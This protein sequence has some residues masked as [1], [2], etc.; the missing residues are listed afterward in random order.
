MALDAGELAAIPGLARAVAA[1]DASALEALRTTRLSVAAAAL[2][3]AADPET[4]ALRPEILALVEAGLARFPVLPEESEAGA[5]AAARMAAPEGLFAAALLL[6][7]HDLPAIPDLAPMSPAMRAVVGTALLIAPALF[8]SESE[9]ERHAERMEAIVEAFHRVVVGRPEDPHRVALGLIFAQRA[10]LLMAYFSR[11]NLRR[12]MRLRGEIIEA[13][14]VAARRAPAHVFGAR[15]PGPL[16]V[17]VLIQALRPFTETYLAISQFEAKDPDTRLT[18][19]ALDAAPG[20]IE[21]LARAKADDYVVLGSDLEAQ[22]ARLRSDDLDALAI[23]SNVTA[24]VNPVALLA[25][26]RS[27]RVQIVSTVTPATSGFASG[28]AYLSGADNEPGENPQSDYTE[29]LYRVPGIVNYYAY[30]HDRDPATVSVAR[31]D[32]GLPEGAPVFFS[33][34]NFF[35]L[36]PELTALWARVLAQVPEAR[37]LIMPFAPSWSSTYFSRPF[38]ERIEAQFAAAGVGRDRWRAV[39]PVPARADLHRIAAL[40]DVYLDAHPFSGA[41]SLID[42]LSVGLPVVTLAGTRFRGHVGAAMLAGAGLSGMV[43]RDEADYVAKAAALARDPASRRAASAR[44]RAAMSPLPPYFDV[45]AAGRKLGD[46]VRSLTAARDA[47]LERLRGRASADLVGAIERVARRASGTPLFRA[48]TDT[49]IVKL[50][51]VPYLRDAAQQGHAIDVGACV[52]ETASP[53]LE[54]GWGVDLF[55]PDPACGAAMAGLAARFPGR[56]RHRASLV[57]EITGAAAFFRSEVGLSGRAPSA[58]GATKDVA[59]LPSTRLDDFARAEGLARVDWLKVDCEGYDFDALLSHDFE[60]LPPRL[61]LVEYTTA[62]PRQNEAAVAATLDAMARH[63]YGALVFGYEDGGNFK[64][65]V[66]D[67]WC[68]GLTSGDLPRCAAGHS[69]GNILFFRRE[70]REFLA[71]TA[72]ALAELLPGSERAAALGEA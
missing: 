44:V 25:A 62:H 6:R 45:A 47:R 58:Y 66:W 1:G 32:L 7:P 14:L 24:V 72:L 61:A 35:K 11:R 28:D 43:A 51:A 26:C 41:C 67:Y 31:A 36:G 40:C 54:M 20:P 9:G 37:L 34:A 12:A 4:L 59:T 55:E 71:R 50:L 39:Q 52:G 65:R 42:P 2:D 8:E 15:K 3:G 10:N 30:Q 5:R 64:R 29:V 60:R 46:A 53:F 13:M 22:L 49:A 17:G 70:D 69:Q 33:G 68:V 56:A 57:G 63:G 16:R 19:Y 48:L 38:F 23:H 21:D 27:A 18:V